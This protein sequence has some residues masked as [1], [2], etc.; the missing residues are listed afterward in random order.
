MPFNLYISF[1][2]FVYPFR[3]GFDDPESRQSF[4]QTNPENP[5]KPKRTLT[6]SISRQLDNNRV[7]AF[8]RGEHNV[9]ILHVDNYSRVLFP[10][11]FM[12]FNIFYWGYYLKN[13][14]K[15][16]PT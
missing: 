16:A 12:I 5:P 3:Y 4:I 14:A 1:S 15:S 9:N 6:R 13:S 2:R 11:T 8:F 10:A 7:A